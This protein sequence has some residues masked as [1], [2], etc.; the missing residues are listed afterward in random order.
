MQSKRKIRKLRGERG[1]ILILGAL[2]ILLVALMM[3]LTLN[4]GQSVFEKIRIQ[5]YSDASAFSIATQN[6]RAFNFFAYTNRANVGSLVAAASAHGF[7]SM[8]SSVPEMFNAGRKNFLVF[9]I[10]EM[11]VCV[12]C[13]P[14]CGSCC[15]HCPHALKDYRAMRNYKKKRDSFR[16]K[17]KQLDE[18]FIKVVKA[19]D[20]HMQFI[21]MSQLDVKFRVAMQIIGDQ[22][23]K[24]L[25]D[26]FAP[27][28][29]NNAMGVSGLNL[30]EFGGVFEDDKQ[31]KK[32]VP[33]EIANGSRWTKFVSK[34]TLKDAYL[35]IHPTAVL[36][37][38]LKECPKPTKG[39][40]FIVSH[41]GQSRIIKGANNPKP[42]ITHAQRG[43]DGD[44][45]AGWDKGRLVSIAINMC[46]LSAFMISSYESWVGSS[47]NSGDH[48][49]RRSCAGRD[50][51]K[52]FKCLAG[53]N[54]FTLF[55]ADQNASSDFGQP[56]A[57]SLVSQDLRKMPQGGQGPWEIT[58]SGEINVDLGGEVSKHGMQISNDP[59]KFGEGMALSKAMTYYHLPTD[60][61]EHPNFFN[62]FWK[63]KLQPFR[64]S[65]EAIRV[66]VFGGAGKYI[67]AI[68]S[69]VPLP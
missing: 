16:K 53:G 57:Y 3:L 2:G 5:Q 6:A 12:F 64:G 59:G 7:M 67:P 55:Q 35:F 44:A 13:G 58:D 24:K 65:S 45:A 14:E 41:K 31:K 30:A 21:S 4:V 18:K 32:W 48:K 27:Q 25:R 36:Q 15:K 26:R 52:N 49:E 1:Q 63:A 19:L 17:V 34:R 23:T 56:M 40:S 22:L 60:W 8:A 9:F 20:L 50:R 62:P 39:Y 54:C 28:A 46:I 43:P 11:A 51:H 47:K 33:T 61:K 69:G 66:L 68:I 42:R 29:S 37:Q 10:A 38:I